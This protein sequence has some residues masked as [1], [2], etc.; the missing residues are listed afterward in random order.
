MNKVFLTGRFANNPSSFATQK[1]STPNSK[2]DIVVSDSRMVNESYFFPCVCFGS[3][4]NYINSYLKKGDFVIIEGR[5]T[6]KKYTT[7]DGK[8]NYST[9]IIVDDIQLVSNSYSSYSNSKNNI[10]DTNDSSDNELDEKISIDDAFVKN[11]NESTKSL[12]EENKKLLDDEDE[13]EAEYPLW[14]NEVDEN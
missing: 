7:K 14:M 12:Q 1:S 8:I 5:I 3:R 4:A 13:D 11:K 9:D 10:S 6:R 2:F